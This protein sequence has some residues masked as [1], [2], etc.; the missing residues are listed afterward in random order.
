MSSIFENSPTTT[1]TMTLGATVPISYEAPRSFNLS[2]DLG[3][4][5]LTPDNVQVN[6]GVPSM[7]GR[8]P[9]LRGNENAFIRARV[10]PYQE[11]LQRRI[12]D[13]DRG[14]GMRGVSGSLR[15]NELNNAMIA[16]NREIANQT[17]LAQQ[18]AM[19]AEQDVLKSAI[20]QELATMGLGLEG[21]RLVLGDRRQ[22]S[23]AI[24]GTSSQTTT[25]GGNL[26]NALPGIA[27]ILDAF[28]IGS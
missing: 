3:S 6:S 11:A 2:G 9:D 23:Q 21:L 12:A 16:G 7:L 20:A 22:T 25:G 1:N 19:G 24:G 28:N 13:I 14:L 4:L 18:E 17:A 8:L 10:S 15:N 27:S 26:A 5:N